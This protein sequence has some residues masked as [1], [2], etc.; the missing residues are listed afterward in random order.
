M[1]AGQA[2]VR[3]CGCFAAGDGP[4]KRPAVEWRVA[5]A[6]W[7][8]VATSIGRQEMSATFSRLSGSGRCCLRAIAPRKRGGGRRCEGDRAKL[9]DSARVCVILEETLR[10]FLPLAS[11]HHRCIHAYLS[12]CLPRWLLGVCACG[13]GGSLIR[14]GRGGLSG[15]GPAGPSTLPLVSTRVHPYRVDDP[16]VLQ[17]TRAYIRMRTDTVP[18]AFSS[19]LFS[20]SECLFPHCREPRRHSCIHTGEEIAL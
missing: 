17:V 19:A 10:F 9:D 1:P 13:V 2:V 11:L 8:R 7:Q 4:G 3:A 18:I 5:H 16:S 15:F 14:D 20:L 12:V 6:P